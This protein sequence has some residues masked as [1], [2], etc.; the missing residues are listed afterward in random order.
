LIPTYQPIN[1]PAK[2]VATYQPTNHIDSNFSAYQPTYQ[3]GSNLSTYQP[4]WFQ[5]PTYQ[6]N[7]LPTYLPADPPS[8]LEPSYLPGK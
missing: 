5:V 6:T 8:G 4:S 1:L 3:V 7:Y 2:L